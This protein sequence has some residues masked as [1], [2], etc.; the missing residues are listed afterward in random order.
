MSRVFANGSGN[1]VS[2]QRLKNWYR[3]NTQPYKVW[4]KGKVEQSREGVAPFPTPWFSNYWKGGPSGHPRLRSLTLLLLTSGLNSEFSF[5]KTGCPPKTKESSLPFY[6]LVARE[7]HALA[8]NEMQTTSN[9]WEL[10]FYLLRTFP[11]HLGSFC[12]VSSFT[13]FRPNFTSGLLQ[14]IALRGPWRSG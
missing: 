6:L 7:T 3:L 13:T 14:V 11:P 9:N 1:L 5:S 4:I 2:I 8:L 10:I 12:V